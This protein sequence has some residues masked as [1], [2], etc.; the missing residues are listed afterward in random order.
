MRR[1]QPGQEALKASLTRIVPTVRIGSATLSREAR[2][3][4][5]R[6]VVDSHLHLPDMF[7]ITFAAGPG[8]VTAHTRLALGDPVTIRAG[9][10]GGT[11]TAELMIGEV[12]S[13]EAMFTDSCH[14]VI[15]G[16]SADHRLQ[17]VRRT[18]T[19]LNSKVSDIARKIAE[20]AKLPVG[21]IEQTRTAHDHLGQVNQ[22]DW[23]FLSGQ[24]ALIGYEFGVTGGRFFFRK[25][26][27]G[28]PARPITLTYPDNLR[29]FLP[30][31]TTGNLAAEAEVR[32]W[33]PLSANVRVDTVPVAASSARLNGCTPA[34]LAKLFDQVSPAPAKPAGK[35]PGPGRGPEPS[36]RAF[37][38]SDRP[39]ATGA[40]IGVAAQE[41]VNGV[42]G[43]LG[44]TFAEAEGEA[45]GDPRLIAGAGL[46]I[47][48]VSRVFAGRW[49]LTKAQHVFD[50]SGYHTRFEV[51][52]T[53][54]RSLLGL[55]TAAAK[56]LPAMPGLV[57]GV[58]TNVMDPL[59]KC[60]VKVCLP[61]LSPSYESDWAPVTQF[62]AGASGGAMFLPD[63][64][65]EVLVGFEFGD[66]QRAYVLGALVNKRSGYRPGG[67][68]I[69]IVGKTASVVRRGFT[70]ASGTML[71]FHDE[72]RPPVSEVVLGTQDGTVALTIDQQRKTVRVNCSRPGGSI[73]VECGPTGNID[74][75]AGAGGT[76]TIDG[77]AQLNLT[78]QK[79]IKIESQGIVE[80]K[81][82]QVKLN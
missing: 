34:D 75:I 15:R 57:C 16:Y 3:K 22:T 29:A 20:E 25:A 60:R 10:P 19:F 54:Q 50:V 65:D 42:A 79:G 17:R 82:T 45:I 1:A 38:V 41:A 32:V 72:V 18:R 43:Q 49:V 71:A 39:V 81:G 13:I 52:G 70:S 56:P 80:I 21:V 33:D 58:V 76:V 67:D 5:D 8:E 7:E 53:Q 47:D 68:P 31:V 11:A 62:G 40:A 27:G 12:T 59:G 35:P 24:A 77:G 46:T 55:T 63:V 69:K 48:G 61:W 64:D 36:T 14:T 23:D 73:T 4:L 2:G 44:S 78:A 28:P 30:R 6:V 74:I 37:V 9:A 26:A 66:P 51:S